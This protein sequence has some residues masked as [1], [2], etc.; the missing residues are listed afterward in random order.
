MYEDPWRHPES[1]YLD[2]P[3]Q[4]EEKKV[5]K[6]ACC[7]KWI[8]TCDDIRTTV[9]KSETVYLHDDCTQREDGWDVY[10]SLQQVEI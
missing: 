8:E 5:V 9:I 10:D 4:A 7:G 1:P 6:C 2:V 3:D